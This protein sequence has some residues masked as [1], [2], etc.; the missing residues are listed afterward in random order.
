MLT[1]FRRRSCEYAI[2]DDHLVQTVTGENGRGYSHRCSH[3]V[4]REVA[5][6]FEKAGATGCT[7]IAL[8]KTLDLPYTQVNVALEFL[9]ERGSVV[10]RHRRNYAASDF[11]YEDALIEWHALAATAPAE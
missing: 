8:A 9:K 2:E 4:Y 1:R 3:E 11:V 6:A 10:T 5:Y 7:Y